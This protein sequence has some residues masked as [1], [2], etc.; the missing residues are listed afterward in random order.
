M[1]RYDRE[2]GSEASA[3]QHAARSA[4]VC[5][6]P[7]AW[8]SDDPTQMALVRENMSIEV[9]NLPMK[10]LNMV[11]FHSFISLPEGFRFELSLM[12]LIILYVSVL[13][14]DGFYIAF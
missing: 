4:D 5:G 14:R 8:H 12:Y 9:A 6:L 7:V 2:R 3:A 13:V 10:Q 1:A 11:I